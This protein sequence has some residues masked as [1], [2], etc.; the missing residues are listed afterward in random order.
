MTLSVRK[1]SLILVTLIMLLLLGTMLLYFGGIIKNLQKEQSETR[2]KELANAAAL[3]LDLD[4]LE[5]FKDKVHRVYSKAMEPVSNVYMDTPRYEEYMS[6]FE[7]LQE[8]PEFLELYSTLK[9]LHQTAEVDCLYLL[10]PDKATQAA[11]YLVDVGEDK[12]C[13]PGSFDYLSGEDLNVLY[14]PEQTIGFS[15]TNPDVY[16]NITGCA[17]PITDEANNVIAYIGVDVSLQKLTDQRNRILLNTALTVLA[18]ALTFCS[19]GL[20]M[21]GQLLLKPI[22]TEQIL[23]EES[24][25][26]KSENITL[27]RKAREAQKI[28]ELT[29]SITALLS[30]MPSMTYSKDLENGKYLACNQMFAEHAHKNSSKQVVGLTDGDLFDAVTA[31]HGRETDSIAL[32]MA[33]P[34]IFHEEVQDV[35]GNVKHLQTTK[36]KFTDASGREC[37]LGMSVDVTELVNLRQENVETRAA[38]EQVLGENLTYARIAQELS[39]DYIFLY[40]VD[41][42]SGKYVEYSAE[43]GALSIEIAA[44]GDSFFEESLK[45]AKEIIYKDDYEEF[46]KAFR[47]ENILATIDKNKRFIINYRLIMDGVPTYV[48]LKAVRLEGED[49][50]LLIGVTGSSTDQKSS[51][52]QKQ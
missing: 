47:K 44:E 16:G 41:V 23:K 49:D 19:V 46:S 4:S 36:L 45:N 17:V 12:I 14:D 13:R 27:A 26:L 5:R 24:E 15:V 40:Y 10:Y 50:H 34:Y 11:V 7:G 30:N 9:E 8:E 18:A 28:T 3:C 31:E 37:L 43:N 1:K 52:N 38:Y 25:K 32:K 42:N 21:S 2:A 29:E 6:Q 22:D 39:K 51:D 48:Y 35:N 20:Y 33:E